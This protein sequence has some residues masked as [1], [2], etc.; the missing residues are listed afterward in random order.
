MLVCC[1]LNINVFWPT[2]LIYLSN[3]VHRFQL[4]ITDLGF[5]KSVYFGGVFFGIGCTLSCTPHVTTTPLNLTFHPADI[6]LLSCIYDNDF[7]YQSKFGTTSVKGLWYIMNS[8]DFCRL[9]RKVSHRWTLCLGE[10]PIPRFQ[11]PN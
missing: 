2:T 6:I 11:W 10:R 5:C 4:N 3:K 9:S 1:P 8:I 7:A